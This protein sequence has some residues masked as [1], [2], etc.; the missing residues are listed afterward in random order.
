MPWIICIS[1]FPK[2]HKWE[3]MENKQ[4]G[5]IT[6]NKRFKNSF[7]YKMIIYKGQ[8]CT[9]ITSALERLRQEDC[10]KTEAAS[11]TQ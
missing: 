10:H 6:Q 4:K 11:G 1:I 9:T 8:W 7:T 2:W 3:Q 5:K